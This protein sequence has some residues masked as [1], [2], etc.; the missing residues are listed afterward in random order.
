[1]TSDHA[2]DVLPILS[3]AHRGFDPAIRGYDRAQ[4][5]QYLAHLEDDLR[6]TV[7]ERDAALA[8]SADMAAQLASAQ[9][10][11]ESLRRQLRTASEAVTIET[12]DARVRQLIEAAQSDAT[13]IRDEAQAQAEVVRNGAAD[14]AA[15]TRAAAHAEA[16]RIVEQATARHAEADEMFRRRIA[17]A[18][19][20]RAAIEEQLA[21]TL[22]QTRAEESRLTQEAAAERARLDA[23][24]KA[25]RHRLEIAAADERIRLDAESLTARTQ[26]DDDFEI[27]LRARRTAA[28][29]AIERERHEAEQAAA[30]L[31]SDAQAEVR[32]LHTVRDETHATLQSLHG[33]LGAALTEALADTPSEIG[34]PADSGG[35]AASP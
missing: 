14:A 9:A 13:R 7:A 4:V 12:V 28:N 35:S 33:K 22:E 32:R 3:D 23:A 1:M 30:A 26:A 11:I 24:A 18:E 17:E 10:Q 15:R 6:S 16:E 29:E 5:D 31:I 20:H 25:D 21:H 2:S 27:T 19:Q 34:Q 8:R